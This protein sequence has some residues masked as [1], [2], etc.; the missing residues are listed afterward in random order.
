MHVQVSHAL[1]I[2]VDSVDAREEDKG[3]ARTKPHFV[4]RIDRPVCCQIAE[5]VVIYHQPAWP[6]SVSLR[7]QHLLV[8]CLKGH[9]R[10]E[11][12]VRALR[13][14]HRGA[15]H[16]GLEAEDDGLLIKVLQ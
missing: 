6:L 1:L 3:G 16:L 12:I 13:E 7:H 2:H 9:R 4:L 11:Y 8:E 15:E 5:E 14:G 10:S